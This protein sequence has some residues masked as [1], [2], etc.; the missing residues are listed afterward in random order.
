M[1]PAIS[2]DLPLPE[3]P[4]TKMVSFPGQTVTCCW[5]ASIR[6]PKAIE[7]RCSLGSNSAE[8]SASNRSQ[9]SMT[10]SPRSR[11]RRD[12][13]SAGIEVVLKVA[14]LEC[15]IFLGYDPHV[16]SDEAPRV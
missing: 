10:P 4:A 3:V 13:E 5:A 14:R 15:L 2:V 9:S 11:F 8:S 12:P 6:L 7:P 1:I 16:D